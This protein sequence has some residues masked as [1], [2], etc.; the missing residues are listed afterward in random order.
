MI[1]GNSKI[2]IAHL[3][4]LMQ[5]I[6]YYNTNLQKLHCKSIKKTLSSQVSEN[7]RNLMHCHT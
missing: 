6:L 2:F 3:G 7:P 5:S 4:M 1:K